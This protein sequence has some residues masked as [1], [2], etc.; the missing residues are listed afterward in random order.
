MGSPAFKEAWAIGFSGSWASRCHWECLG[1]AENGEP[2]GP[3]ALDLV[4]DKRGC[5]GW[6]CRGSSWLDSG[7]PE[8]GGSDWERRE[9]FYGKLDSSSIDEGLL[10]GSPLQIPMKRDSPWF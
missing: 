1:R 3:T 10:C 6:S 7:R 2:M 8:L 5:Y 9:A 4:R